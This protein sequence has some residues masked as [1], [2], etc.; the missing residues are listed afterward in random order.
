M[1]KRKHT[2]HGRRNPSSAWSSLR[3]TLALLPPSFAC[4][5]PLYAVTMSSSSPSRKSSALRTSSAPTAQMIARFSS[6]STTRTDLRMRWKCAFFFAHARALFFRSAPTHAI[7]INK[8]SRAGPC[9]LVRPPRCRY[10]AGRS[11]VVQ[12]VDPSSTSPSKK[13]SVFEGS[14]RVE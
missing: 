9:F 1:W 7:R 11:P 2:T 6:Q 10:F 14:L 3:L 5:S 12:R 13:N 8:H 4:W